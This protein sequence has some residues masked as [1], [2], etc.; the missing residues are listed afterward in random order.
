LR[1]NA[2][3][4]ERMAKHG[5]GLIGCGMIAE[6]HTRAVAEIP[7]ARVVAACDMIEASVQKIVKLA[8]GGCQGFTDIEAMLALPEIDVVCVCTPSGSH[9]EPAVKAAAAGKHV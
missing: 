3:E 6:F 1:V 9:M 8:G 4:S 2:G 5:F 7:D